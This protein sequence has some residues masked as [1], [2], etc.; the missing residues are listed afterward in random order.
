V[1]GGGVIV[2]TSPTGVVEA[3]GVGVIPQHPPGSQPGSPLHLV[4]AK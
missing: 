3:V 4:L 2:A 1:G